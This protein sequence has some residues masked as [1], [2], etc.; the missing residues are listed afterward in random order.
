M[1]DASTTDRKAWVDQLDRITK[2][3]E[4]Q[5]VTIEV[6]DRTYGDGTEAE[7]MPFGYAS[8][9]QNDDVAIVAVGGNSGRYP[10]ALRH[11]VWHPTEIDVDPEAG[12]V[13]LVEPDG[14][15]TIVSFLVPSG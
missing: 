6:V 7:R 9:D 12:A 4:G 1:A 13:K 2:E 10:V 14:T 11:M 3:R 15:T 8:Y 5:Y